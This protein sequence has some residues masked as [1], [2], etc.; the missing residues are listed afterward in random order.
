MQ[1]I[2]GP[3]SNVICEVIGGIQRPFTSMND[4]DCVG[5]TGGCT[6]IWLHICVCAI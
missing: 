1:D 3:F 2:M 5:Q 6:V 4:S